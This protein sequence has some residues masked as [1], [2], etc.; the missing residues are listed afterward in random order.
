MTL[1]LLRLGEH[2]VLVEVAGAR[3]VLRVT[4]RLHRL[5][6][7]AEGRLEVVP[8][9]R[10]VMVRAED[11]ADLA[12]VASV[13]EVA[14][15]V[16]PDAA[17]H[18]G[19][20]PDARSGPTGSERPDP[21]IGPSGPGD[22]DEPPGPSVSAGADLDVIVVPVRYDGPDLE[23]V[24][25]LTGLGEDEVVL[26]HTGVV[27]TVAFI[28][29]APG[30]AYLAGGDPRLHVPRRPS[31]RTSVP[32]GAVGLAGEWSGIYPRPSPGGWQL[33]GRTELVLWDVER[34]PPAL[35][36]PGARVRFEAT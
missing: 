10:T 36:T 15:V 26:A 29:F 3:E 16:E 11:P 7:V 28:G 12:P 31:P 2:A 34:D 20:G 8:A 17:R 35:L 33:L 13:L 21:A 18:G 25:R 24:A 1:R 23:E 22:P 14:D 6:G 5:P 19:S 4:E 30:F 9:A 27:W 32:A